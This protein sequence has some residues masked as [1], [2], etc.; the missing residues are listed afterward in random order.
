MKKSIIISA[1]S[2][3][4]ILVSCGNKEKKENSTEQAT[5]TSEKVQ[6]TCSMHPEVIS[7]KPSSCPK[8]GMDL[9]VK[10]KATTDSTK[11]NSK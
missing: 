5:A 7:D 11:T 4:L 3:T 2:V 1:I 8:C 9:I 10:E 6:Y